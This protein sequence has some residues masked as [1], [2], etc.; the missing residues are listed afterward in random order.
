MD[1]SHK[2]KLKIFKANCRRIIQYNVIYAT[3]KQAKS[4]NICFRYKHIS[5]KIQKM[6]KLGRMLIFGWETRHVIRQ[7]PSGFNEK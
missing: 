5:K 7:R 1:E 6:V 3:F 4:Y 2:Y